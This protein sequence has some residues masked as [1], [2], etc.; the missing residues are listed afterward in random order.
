[1]TLLGWLDSDVDVHTAFYDDNG[2]IKHPLLA[3]GLTKIT[4]TADGN[5]VTVDSGKLVLDTALLVVD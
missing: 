5:K 3:D 2:L 1:M 4:V